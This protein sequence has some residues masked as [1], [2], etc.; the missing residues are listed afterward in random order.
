MT[1]PSGGV[2]RPKYS[3]SAETF[4][5][6]AS[7]NARTTPSQKRVPVRMSLMFL[8][9]CG[10][11]TAWKLSRGGGGIKVGRLLAIG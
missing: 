4:A 10:F 2:T 5:Q 1:C 11:G 8:S 7:P 6:A 3:L 9:W